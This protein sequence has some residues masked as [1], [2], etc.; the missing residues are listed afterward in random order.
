M[1]PQWGSPFREREESHKP[2]HLQA[3]VTAALHTK[4]VETEGS[5]LQ[6]ARRM[7]CCFFRRGSCSEQRSSGRAL[8]ADGTACAKAWK[9]DGPS[10]RCGTEAL[11][12]AVASALQMGRE[13]GRATLSTESQ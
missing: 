2:V 7:G 3:S 12:T 10:I 11:T 5:V 13:V 6:S 8:Q 1:Q 4:S 9:L